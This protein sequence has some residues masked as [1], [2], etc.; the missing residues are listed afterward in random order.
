M[1]PGLRRLAPGSAQLTPSLP[2]GRHLREKMAVLSAYADEALVA[3]AGFDPEPALRAVSRE[4][5]G[6]FA[7]GSL[8][9]CTA[10]RLGWAL[11]DGQPRG[12]GDPGIG[13]LLAWMPA[14][15][16]AIALLCLAFDEDF[17]VID[18]TTATIPWLAVCLPSRWAPAEKVG[19][20]FAE[21]HAPVADNALLVEA[22]ERLARLVT[23]PDRW[24]RFV[25]TISADPRLHQHP[26]RGGTGWSADAD[27]EAIAAMASFRHERQ[28]FIP[29]AA[30]GQAVFTIRI[31]SEP[32]DRALGSRDDA[33]R[34]H[35]A[36]AS[37][38]P[39]VLAYRGLEPVRDR[40]LEALRRRIDVLPAAA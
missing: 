5:P 25:W 10:P 3:A 23:G 32:L 20:H 15:R 21:V 40:L 7:Y 13:E 17:A 24:E 37:M 29:V 1:Q 12:D 36:L 34:L 26:A 19:R 35:D 28:T 38:S 8:L 2:G 33:V 4:A 31:G 18:G 30:T 6:A 9:D 39:A 22:G 11:R 16:R 14:A 27:A